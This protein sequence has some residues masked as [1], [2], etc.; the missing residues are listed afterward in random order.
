MNNLSTA[1]S[2][3]NASRFRGE[4]LQRVYKVWLMR[5]FL[6]VLVLEI[7]ALS[8]VF[9][10]LGRVVFVQ[11]VLENGIQVL[12]LNPPQFLNFILSMFAEAPWAA[13]VLGFGAVLIVALVV[14]HITQGLLRLVLVRQNYFS[15]LAS[16]SK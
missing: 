15:R 6:P 9:Y 16:E 8:I 3:Q 13:R 2:N 7:A 14:R 1:G 10:Q 5:K 11:R 4:V 12:F